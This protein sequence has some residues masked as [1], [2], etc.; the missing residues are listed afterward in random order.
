MI[1]ADCS[2]DTERLS[3]GPWHEI[4]F[5]SSRHRDLAQVIAALLTPA[6]TRNLP[7]PW[8]GDYTIDRA[9]E[10]IAERDDEGVTLLVL[11]RMSGGP[12]GLLLLFEEQVGRGPRR[13]PADVRLGYLLGEES[14]GKGYASE[15][16]AGL[17]AWCRSR[18]VTS[19]A[20]A[21]ADDNPASAGV[22]TKNGFS[23]VADA[24]AAGPGERLYRLDLSP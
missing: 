6:V 18:E 3:A 9:R 13:G 16:V 10:W 22:L 11:E 1:L 7:Q 14:W 24:N 5:E 15:I 4:A 8:S 23:D 2:F 21:V 12:I 17:V 20:G 19:L